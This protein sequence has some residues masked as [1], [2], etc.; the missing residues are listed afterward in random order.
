MRFSNNVEWIDTSAPTVL[1]WSP[2]KTGTPKSKPTVIFSEKMNEAL[3]EAP[4]AFTL[5]KGTRT[6]GVTVAY[7][8]TTTG[9][10]KAILTPNRKLR[11]GVTYTA[12]MTA[13]TTTIWPPLRLRTRARA[14]AT[15]GLGAVSVTTSF[16]QVEGTR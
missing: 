7:V 14:S 10:Y 2:R 13:G 11:S 1:G 8:E 6:V 12:S 15:A 16:W 5:K 4:G 3:V 9:Q